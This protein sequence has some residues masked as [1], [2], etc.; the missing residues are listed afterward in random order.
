M[1]DAVVIYVLGGTP[2]IMENLD[3]S[4]SISETALRRFEVLAG[5]RSVAT[6]AHFRE[7][8]TEALKLYEHSITV[9]NTR[10]LNH[11]Q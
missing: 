1:N 2:S 4:T 9:S 3:T 5:K 10:E 11:Q 6:A 8:F 7:I